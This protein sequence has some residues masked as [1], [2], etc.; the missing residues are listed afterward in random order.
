M[1]ISH[2]HQCIFVHIPKNGG[3]SFGTIM[4]VCRDGRIENRDMLVGPIISEDL[5]AR[6]FLSPTL[7]HLTAKQL[8]E[9]IPE[10]TFS[11]YFKFAIVRNPWDRMLSQY[12]F[13]VKYLGIVEQGETS[14]ELGLAYYLNNF[15]DPQSE[16]RLATISDRGLSFSRQTQLSFIADENDNLLV[17]FVARFETLENDFLVIRDRAGF[18]T[19]NLPYLNATKHA[20]YS[21]YYN[22]ESKHIVE[23]LFARD[24]DF[25][26]HRFEK[27]N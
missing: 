17:D 24:I 4:E 9:V 19:K 2:K 16:K 26:G 10:Q 8:L 13:N 25:F 14:T 18:A 12:L 6:G 23:E 5:K 15:M 7:D 11:N 21:E 1:P 20:H 22:E 3:T 27:N